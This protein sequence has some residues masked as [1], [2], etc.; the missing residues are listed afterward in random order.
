MCYG[1]LIG[2]K[3]AWFPLLSACR[4]VEFD[5]FII[6]HAPVLCF[7]SFLLQDCNIWETISVGIRWFTRALRRVVHSLQLPK[8]SDDDKDNLEGELTISDY[9][10][11]FNFGKSPGED[12]FTVEFYIKIFE[13]LAFD[14]VESLNTAF[15][16]GH[17]SISQR[18]KQALWKTDLLVRIYV[19]YVAF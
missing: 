11:R 8:L 18:K 14:L 9:A 17:L 1:K 10:V 15:S 7:C 2:H 13:L 16:R 4:F 3:S 12:G 6:F 5:T 19:Y